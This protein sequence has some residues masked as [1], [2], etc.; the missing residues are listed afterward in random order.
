MGIEPIKQKIVND[1]NPT[2]LN[3]Q[4]M[5]AIGVSTDFEAVIYNGDETKPGADIDAATVSCK[6]FCAAAWLAA[7]VPMNQNGSR[8]KGSQ[9]IT[10]EQNNKLVAFLKANIRPEY[11]A[12]IQWEPLTDLHNIFHEIAQKKFGNTYKNG[13]TYKKTYDNHTYFSAKVWDEEIMIPPAQQKKKQDLVNAPA[14][15]Y[16]TTQQLMDKIYNRPLT[17]LVA[18]PSKLP[19][20][21]IKTR[22]P[23]PKVV[24]EPPVK[25]VSPSPTYTQPIVTKLPV[26]TLKKVEFEVLGG[27]NLKSAKPMPVH[28]VMDF[29]RKKAA[30]EAHLNRA[31]FIVG[32]SIEK[33]KLINPNLQLNEN[34]IISPGTVIYA[35][36]KRMN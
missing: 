8:I 12:G 29:A 23:T 14:P 25:T 22:A 5:N 26:D 9:P 10:A 13:N 20:P 19:Q 34:S 15:A 33:L 31:P 28:E 2:Y 32:D 16:M 6:E 4:A 1:Q 17:P 36:R 3:S 30:A 27:V 11:L 35:V 7:G 18:T 21:R 24:K